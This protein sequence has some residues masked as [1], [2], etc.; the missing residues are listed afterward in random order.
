MKDDLG[1]SKVD[2]CHHVEVAPVLS[3]LPEGILLLMS[4]FL[5]EVDRISSSY[6]SEDKGVVL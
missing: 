6:V 3:S 1:A 5:D 4:E 2:V